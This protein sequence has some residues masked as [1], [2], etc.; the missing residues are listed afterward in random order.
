MNRRG[1]IRALV[2]R[3]TG[4]KP[5][6]TRMLLWSHLRG[7]PYGHSQICRH[8][9]AMRVAAAHNGF[10]WWPC[11]GI[12]RGPKGEMLADRAHAH[13]GIPERQT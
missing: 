1:L 3:T 9:R 13:G 11:F 2:W 10:P 4:L 8:H 7:H 5:W 12:E 6:Y